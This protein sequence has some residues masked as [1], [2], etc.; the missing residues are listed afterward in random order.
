MKKNTIRRISA[1]AAAAVL[2][3][4]ATAIFAGCT[5]NNPQITITY[6]F[7]GKDY[8]VGYSLSRLDAPK[9]VTHFLELADAG[10]Y[11]G[12]CIHDYDANFL[13]SGG[14]KIAEGELEEVNYFETVK[15]LEADKKL[16]L[17]Q[18]VWKQDKSTALN[19]VYGEFDA[20]GNR[21]ANGHEYTHK[22]GAL[23][24]YYSDKGNF[25]YK[26]TTKRNDGGKGNGGDPYDTDKNYSY[27]SATSLFYTFLGESNSTRDNKYAVFGMAND[28]KGQLQPMITA[29]NE[30]ISD[31]KDDDDDSEYSF[32]TE[33]RIANVNA[34]EQTGDADFEELRRGNI[35]VTYQTP[36]EEPI[37]IKSVK[38]N[39]Y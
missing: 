12:M 23:V 34:N 3:A 17:T 39:K 19:T 31:H 13:Y 35:E 29:I 1:I 2:T 22:A 18:T 4:G 36:M 8:E 21:P 7:N 14:Y 15:Q 16:K 20:N 32:T 9:T 6:T 10:Y 24:M 11:D 5:S 27:N 25:N 33:Q 28:Y 37:V 30:Y 26:V 38:V